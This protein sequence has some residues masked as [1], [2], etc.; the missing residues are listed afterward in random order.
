M[1]Y[2]A[3]DHLSFRYPQ[4]AADAEPGP[5]GRKPAAASTLT[6]PSAA[7]SDINLS[8]EAG[9]FVVL[10][11]ASGCGKTTL[12]RQLKPALTPAGT[13][14]GRVL[15]AERPLDTWSARDA[16]ARI[17]FLL[18]DPDS[19]IVS[20]TVAHELAFG[21]ENLGYPSEEIRLRVAEMASF[22]GIQS[23]FHAATGTL[24]GGQKQLLNLASVMA[25]RPELLL[26]DEPTSQLDPIAATN[27]LATLKRIS[28]ETGTTILLSEHRLEEVVALADRVLVLEEGHLIANTAPALLGATLLQAHS[29]LVAA[30]PT[31]T[32]LFLEGESLVC[33]CHKEHP[34]SRHCEEHPLPCHCEAAEH[35]K[36]SPP[37]R[38]CEERSDEAIQTG[39]LDSTAGLPRSGKAFARNDKK[40]GLP[41]PITVREG[42]AYLQTRLGVDAVSGPVRG[43]EA[44]GSPDKASGSENW[45]AETVF[46]E[47]LGKPEAERGP[48]DR[49]PDTASTPPSAPL[50]SLEEV[51]FRYERNSADVLR[52]LSLEVYPGELLALVG[53]NAAGKTTTL[54][55]IAGL[56][57][58]YRGRVKRSAELPSVGATGGVVMLPQDPRLLFTHK[59]VREELEAT[60]R[61]HSRDAQ[62]R[63]AHLAR[64][65]HQC[66][67]AGLL[68]RHPFDVSGGEA[69]RIAVADVLLARPRLLLLDE[70]TKGMD[71]AFKERFAALLRQLITDEGLTVVMVSHDIEFCARHADRCGLCFDGQIIAS[72]PPR[73]FFSGLSYY[74]T[75]ARR[76]SQGL[77]PAAITLEDLVAA[78]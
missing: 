65:I 42:R 35:A 70:P 62:E 5:R 56:L 73:E 41:A 30:L 77:A 12:L 55:A 27:F 8:I 33:H 28:E 31:A 63:T 34:P 44:G 72:A 53:D 13:R 58:P 52:G 10:C 20:E 15:L 17:G 36:A 2:L 43:G 45:L 6:A 48:R 18:Q 39:S 26:L 22:F 46:S 64:V 23:W 67:I 68:D 54:G 9:E 1:A 38:H 25:M 47:R 78:L 14:D 37:S 74:T 75:A 19:Q 71:G 66:D 24:S 60:A 40:G 49:K 16:A 57:K 21:L 59:T 29:P 61:Q 32:R 7:L 11:G 3:L 4:A 76:I 51:W 50:L 69:E